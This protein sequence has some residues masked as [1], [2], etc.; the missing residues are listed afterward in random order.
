VV[1]RFEKYDPSKNAASYG[2]GGNLYGNPEIII[3]IFPCENVEIVY[4][5][6]GRYC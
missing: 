1:P 6:F 4:K 3:A 5:K 2:A